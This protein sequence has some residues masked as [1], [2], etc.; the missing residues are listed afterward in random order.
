MV[1]MCQVVKEG[2]MT[3]LAIFWVPASGI[4]ST[5]LKVAGQAI[6]AGLT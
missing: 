3:G 1:L 5:A 4:D 2:D 6:V